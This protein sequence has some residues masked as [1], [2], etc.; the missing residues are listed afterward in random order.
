MSKTQKLYCLG[1]TGYMYLAL[2]LVWQGLEKIIYGEVQLRT[3]DDIISIPILVITYLMFKFK[4]ERDNLRK[5]LDY[6]TR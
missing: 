4:T 2:C 3:V 1:N 6:E 5:V